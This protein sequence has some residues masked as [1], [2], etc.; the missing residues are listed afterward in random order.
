MSSASPA[1]GTRFRMKF[2]SLGCSCSIASESRR[3]RSAVMA[4]ARLILNSSSIYSCRRTRGQNILKNEDSYRHNPGRIYRALWIGSQVN[5]VE[6]SEIPTGSIQN[7]QSENKDV[8]NIRR[9][10]PPQGAMTEGFQARL[11][12][13][14]DL[15]LRQIGELLPKTLEISE[16]VFIDDACQ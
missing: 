12:S 15:V 10:L 2:R 11:E 6:R 8:R 5:S 3:S 13:L 16:G 14:E 4:F 9:H 7:L 1:S